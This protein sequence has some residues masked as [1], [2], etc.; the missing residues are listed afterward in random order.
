MEIEVDGGVNLENI[1]DI[2]KAGANIFVAGNA[3][4]KSKDYSTTI[5]NMKELLS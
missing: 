2:H 3:I 1:S 5:K 4:F